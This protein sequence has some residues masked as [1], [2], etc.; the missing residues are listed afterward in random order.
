MKFEDF[1]KEVHAECYM[2]TDDKMPDSYERFLED[3]QIDDWIRFAEKW[4][5]KITKN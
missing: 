3:L 2:G 4:K 5:N 1:L